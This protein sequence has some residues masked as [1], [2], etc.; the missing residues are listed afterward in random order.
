MRISQ[1]IVIQISNMIS[2]SKIDVLRDSSNFLLLKIG[3][4]FQFSLIVK[5]IKVQPSI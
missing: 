5:N 3:S 1:F 2:A 4:F